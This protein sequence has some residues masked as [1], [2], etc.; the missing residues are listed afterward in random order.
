MPQT[1]APLPYGCRQV[2]LANF[3]TNG[4]VLGTKVALPNSRTFTF[5]EGYDSTELRGDDT[6][7]AKRGTENIEVELEGGGISFEAWKTMASGTIVETGVTPNQIKKYT[8]RTGHSRPDCYTEGRALSE[9]G[10]DFHVRVPRIKYDGDL[11]GELNDQEFWLT[12]ASG[13]GLPSLLTADQDATLG[14]ITYEFVQN[15]TATAI[16]VP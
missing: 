7:V 8:K 4:T 13:T 12:G 15:E 3:T 14:A 1:V 9:S 11:T 2:V 5:T 10:G 6:V 16:V